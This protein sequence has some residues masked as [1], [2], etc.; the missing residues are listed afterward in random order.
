MKID[1][2]SL[3]ILMDHYKWK[4]LEPC[5]FLP[6]SLQNKRRVWAQGLQRWSL[7]MSG[8]LQV[9]AEQKEEGTKIKKLRPRQR[10]ADIL[11]T[12]GVL[13]AFQKTSWEGSCEFGPQKEVDANA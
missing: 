7:R 10:V 8:R 6:P 3:I 2:L 12:F 4:R 5:C 11:V 1:L 9:E 13:V